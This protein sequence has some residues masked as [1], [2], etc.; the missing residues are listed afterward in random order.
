MR[1]RPVS[2]LATDTSGATIV[3]F[4]IVAPV[5]GLLLLGAFDTAHS[6]YMRSVLQGIVQKVARDSALE[7]GVATAQQTILDNKVRNSVLA[8]ANKATITFTRRFYRTFST[9]AAAIAEPFPAANDTNHN[10]V[11][12]NNEIFQDDNRNGVR[13]MDGGDS[14]QGGAKDRTLYTVAVSYPRFF[15]LYKLVG[16]SNTT[17]ISAA[18][19]LENQP[20]SDQE[21]YGAPLAGHCNP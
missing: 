6:L 9:A 7:S 13:D 3:E 20:Y 16:G 14:G 15:P 19:V 5:L 12:D 1:R 8:I 2:K 10:G 17:R 4:A 21:T 18:T 11:C